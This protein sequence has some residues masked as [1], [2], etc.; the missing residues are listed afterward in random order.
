MK[1]KWDLRFIYANEEAFNQDLLYVKETLIPAMA[2][3]QGKLGNEGDFVAFLLQEREAQKRFTK[4]Y[5]YSGCASDLN[6]KDVAGNERLNKVE[7]LS[8]E[9]GE[10][11]AW[12]DPEFLSLGLEKIKAI[13]ARHPE[14][15]HGDVP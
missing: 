7:L 15:D 3:Y 11:L 9:Y 14:L 8:Q 6:K 4:L 2:A 1:D 10:K 13:L 5:L 12:S